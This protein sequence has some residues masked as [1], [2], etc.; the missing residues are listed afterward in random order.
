MLWG[1]SRTLLAEHAALS[2]SLCLAG[3]AGA[4]ASNVLVAT[5][6]EGRHNGAHHAQGLG[7]VH[8]QASLIV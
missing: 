5:P 2:S 8:Q 3:C 4:A 1:H 6:H 7:S